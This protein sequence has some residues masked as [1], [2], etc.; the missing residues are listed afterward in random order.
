[1]HLDFPRAFRTSTA[2]LTLGV[3]LAGCGGGSAAGGD[4]S[5]ASVTATATAPTTD[6]S[7][8]ATP[9]TDSAAGAIAADG[10]NSAYIS[11]VANA[12]G[13]QTAA[14]LAGTDSASSVTATSV[15]VEDSG[16]ASPAAVINA[17]ATAAAAAAASTTN[18]AYSPGSGTSKTT[19]AA[20]G[21]SGIGVNVGTLDT[22][23]PEL[24]TID[25]M[26]RAGNWYTGCTSSTKT[27]CSGFSGAA[28][29]FDT[30]EEAKLDLDANGWVKSLPAASDGSTKYRFVSTVL[31]SGVA[32]DGTYVVKY[33]GAGTIAYSGMAAKVAGSSKP[34]RDVV[35]VTNSAKGGIFLTITA[36]TPGNY[37]R[38]IRVY[39]PGGACSGDY[40]VF[41]ADASAC[42]SG[43]GSFVPFES[44]PASKPWYPS[45]FHDLKGFRTLRFMDWMKANSTTVANWADRTPAGARTWN[46]AN[47][48]PVEAM[49]QLASDLGADPWMNLSPYVTDDYV[50]QFAKL[51]HSTM[52][53]TLTLNLE[54]ANEPWNY[55]FPAT[56]WMQAQATKKWASD[57][58]KGA[59]VYLLETNWYAQRL[60]QVCTIV[61]G[62]FGADAG[63]VR[64][65][66]NAQASGSS[67]TNMTLACT[68][69]AS[70][71]GKACGKF[72]DVVAIAPYFGYYIPMPASRSVVTNWFAQDDGGLANLFSEVNG[73]DVLGAVVKPALAALGSGAPSGALAQVKAMAVATKAVLDPYG[74]PMWS[75]EGGQGMV[76]VP[77]ETDA[78]MQ[79][80]IVSANRDPRM[81]TAYARLIS[82]WKAAGGQT[83]TF[84]NHAYVPS[85]YGTWGLKENLTDDAAPKWQAALQARDGTSC[86]WSGC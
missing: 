10:A 64:C 50:H 52:A 39:P 29:A 62:E 13:T 41:A 40:T 45:F 42:T 22:Y 1:M 3:A 56:K 17:G 11:A 23:S 18:L 84:Y 5:S 37:L 31:S 66:A 75:Y 26:K 28:S 32:P 14:S 21:R 15:A 61:K 36:T 67:V 35:Q 60:A 30:L 76:I 16:T 53:S 12:S 74:L 83:F 58:A 27:S 25:L 71:L 2:V 46:T 8:Q 24:P 44:F 55:A 79:A 86:W 54:Y 20:P 43:K 73:A 72:F 34:G 78:R 9:V 82:D 33:D 63:R 7:A 19:G 65:I 47:G 49:L 6:A 77:N 81:G 69:A 68:Y 38:N 51:V 4:D 70:S 57:A 80:L 48:A 59:N 85:K